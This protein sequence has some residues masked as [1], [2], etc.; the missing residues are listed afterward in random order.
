MRPKDS[1]GSKWLIYHE[2]WYPTRK[3]AE[4]WAKNHVLPYSIDHVPNA[5][6]M[7]GNYRKDTWRLRRY[8]LVKYRGFTV[9]TIGMSL[10]EAKRVAKYHKGRKM[11]KVRKAYYYI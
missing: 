2:L 8:R 1:K 5:K 9:Q 6:T 11:I 4:K 7:Y 10:T 3:E